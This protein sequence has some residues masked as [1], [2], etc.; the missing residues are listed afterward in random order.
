MASA[1]RD[2]HNGRGVQR[3]KR[4]MSSRKFRPVTVFLTLIVFGLPVAVLVD[5]LV[6]EAVGLSTLRLAPS[7]WPHKRIVEQSARRL[8]EHFEE[9]NVISEQGW[10][11][12]SVEKSG[13]APIVVVDFPA[14]AGDRAR[15][16]PIYSEL[17]RLCPVHPTAGYWED[18]YVLPFTVYL[19][20]EERAAARAIVRCDHRYDIHVVEAYGSGRGFPHHV[21]EVAPEEGETAEEIQQKITSGSPSYVEVQAAMRNNNNRELQLAL[22]RRPDLVRTY[23]TSGSTLLFDADTPEEAMVLIGF[24]ANPNA[25][26]RNGWSVLSWASEHRDNASVVKILLDSGA[27]IAS[28][29]PEYARSAEL[30]RMLIERDAPITNDSLFEAI[31]EGHLDVARVLYDAGA[32]MDHTSLTTSPL[33]FFVGE[34]LGATASTYE[35]KK[36]RLQAAI[37]LGAPAERTYRG[38]SLWE[39]IAQH[40]NSNRRQEVIAILKNGARH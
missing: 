37:E 6:F 17:I 36:L 4:G 8:E 7:L 10:R 9:T 16:A 3:G 5:V 38:R 26:M 2:A 29:R 22:S 39:F 31:R 15:S 40:P 23:D 34:A 28:A 12:R 20:D 14:H 18:S 1:E 24:G 13:K 21:V 33:H 35:D 32:R 25:Q 30:A 11:L 27:E 19:V